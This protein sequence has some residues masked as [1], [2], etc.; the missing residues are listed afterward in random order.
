MRNQ[1]LLSLLPVIIFTVIDSVYGTVAGVIAGVVFGVGEVAWEYFKLKKV[2]AITIGS[3]AL[4]V[5]LG[6]LSLYEDSGAFFKLQPAILVFVLAAIMLGT[7]WL[8]K[9][10]MAE[11][12]RKQRPDL[13]PVVYDRLAG[14]NFRMGLVLVAIALVGVHAAF[15]WSTAWWATYKAVGAPIMICIYA[16]GDIAFMR[17]RGF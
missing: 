1:L 14:L 15:R 9:P 6:A 17:W 16:L 5:V 10:M 13:P 7:S 2:Q 4:V 8:K 12:M 11:M 3:N